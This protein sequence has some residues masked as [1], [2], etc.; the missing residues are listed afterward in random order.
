[1]DP[2]V[3]TKKPTFYKETGHIALSQISFVMKN[4][5]GTRTHDTHVATQKRLVVKL[6]PL[7]IE[8]WKR[9][10]KLYIIDVAPAKFA[11]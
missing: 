3:Q 11:A 8:A 9:F 1:M 6:R 7:N 4:R 10:L 2:I 5:Q